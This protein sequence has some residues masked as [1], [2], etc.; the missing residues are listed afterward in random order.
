MPFYSCNAINPRPLDS[1]TNSLALH[2]VMLELKPDVT[3]AYPV[4]ESAQLS[5]SHSPS[6]CFHKSPSLQQNESLPSSKVQKT[7]LPPFQIIPLLTEEQQTTATNESS[8]LSNYHQRGWLTH[9]LT[10]NITHSPEQSISTYWP[11]KQ[12]STTFE[13]EYTE[14][15]FYQPSD[16]LKELDAYEVQEVLET[17]QD[18]LMQCIHCTENTIKLLELII[19]EPIKNQYTYRLGIT[20]T[21]SVDHWVYYKNLIDH[22]L[23]DSNN[24]IYQLTSAEEERVNDCN[25]IPTLKYQIKDL[26]QSDCIKLQSILSAYLG[27]NLLIKYK[28]IP[29][30]YTKDID[31]TK[32]I[33]KTDLLSAFTLLLKARQQQQSLI[34]R[35]LISSLAFSPYE[36]EPPSTNHQQCYPSSSFT[37]YDKYYEAY[38]ATR[39]LRMGFTSINQCA[40]LSRY[41]FNS[42]STSLAT[43]H[44]TIT[45]FHDPTLSATSHQLQDAWDDTEILPPPSTNY[46]APQLS[47]LTLT[48]NLAHP[49]SASLAPPKIST[50][51]LT[52][53]LQTQV[54]SKQIQTIGA[55]L[56]EKKAT[57]PVIECPNCK[58]KKASILST[59]K[60][61]IHFKT[62]L[63]ELNQAVELCTKQH[64]VSHRFYIDFNYDNTGEIT[65][66]QS[67]CTSNSRFVGTMTVKVAQVDKSEFEKILKIQKDF[68]NFK[69]IYITL[70]LLQGKSFPFDLSNCNKIFIETY[71][72][73]MPTEELKV[74]EK[75]YKIFTGIQLY[76]HN[77]LGTFTKPIEFKKTSNYNVNRELKSINHH[78]SRK[79]TLSLMFHKLHR[80]ASPPRAPLKN[81]GIVTF[82]FTSYASIN[83]PLANSTSL[84][85]LTE[86]ITTM[87]PPLQLLKNNYTSPIGIPSK[88]PKY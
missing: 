79:Y 4:E 17:R 68:R 1:P 41:S 34:A 36:Y 62:R 64:K 66:L 24:L 8:S 33:Q 82:P 43:P 71:I 54:T 63:T 67:K 31:I 21:Q 85:R 38:E 27:Y 50:F 88:K 51:N 78:T 25:Y 39:P 29:K 6:I 23:T 72:S 2:Q 86:T 5:F 87:P 26:T 75:N 56:Q 35:D 52:A 77:I 70:E 65:V 44:P 15:D 73:N 81:T 30:D 48:S 42:P 84:I 40:D 19:E 10:D 83:S 59:Y 13:T 76:Y 53:L 55:S 7:A 32:I 28:Q 49:T 61:E 3:P 12:I 47:D 69:G 9:T 11:S 37:S 74:L 16:T 58:G 22:N 14:N 46:L 18:P 80:T 20:H 60:S 57:Y 45:P